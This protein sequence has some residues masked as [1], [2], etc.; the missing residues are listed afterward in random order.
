MHAPAYAMH[1]AAFALIVRALSRAHCWKRPRPALAPA[2]MRVLLHA[3]RHA[4]WRRAACACRDARRTLQTHAP[5]R[6]TCLLSALTCEAQQRPARRPPQARAASRRRLR[7]RPASGIYPVGPL[8]IWSVRRGLAVPPRQPDAGRPRKR[9][10]SASTPG[11]PSAST[12]KH[13]LVSQRKC[14]PGAWSWPCRATPPC[15]VAA[16]C[17]ARAVAP[18]AAAP[19][20]AA[21]GRHPT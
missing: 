14:S 12:P 16:V 17:L 18:Q 8:W 5:H 7:L 3:C 15:C 10:S 13:A 9:P 2:G 6:S 1:A 20:A 21:T 19:R 4:R 11:A